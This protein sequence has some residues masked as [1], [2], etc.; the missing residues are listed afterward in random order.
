MKKLIFLLF[1]LLSVITFLA[2]VAVS[3]QA[4]KFHNVTDTDD[5]RFDVSD[6]PDNFYKITFVDDKEVLKTQIIEKGKTATP[7]SPKEK[8]GYIFIGW[9]WNGVPFDFSKKVYSS[10]VLTAVWKL[11]YYSAEFIAD[12]K[13]VRTEFFTV[14]DTS[15]KEPVVPE[16]QFYYGC[17]E[18]YKLGT[19]D[20]KIHAIYTPIVYEINYYADNTHVTTLK[21]SIDDANFS[22]PQVPEIFGFEGYWKL[23]KV[24]GNSVTII[25]AYRPKQFT[26][27]FKVN[28]KDFSV[29]NYGFG[30][31][32]D[33]PQL[34]QVEGY[35]ASWQP[36]KLSLKEITIVE[37]V[38]TPITYYAKFFVNGKLEY[39]LPFDVENELNELPPLP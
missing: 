23:E 33:E 7:L 35:I 29:Q 5:N 12:D 8:A 17:W 3:C 19:S 37:A 20:I 18:N 28:G 25:A 21:Y 6:L 36:Y 26:V 30:E 4:K 16:K 31:K 34:P 11:N 24:N 22:E 15:L 32:V 27:I 9:H 10:A 38:Y 2:L 14:K 39:T 13:I 1:S